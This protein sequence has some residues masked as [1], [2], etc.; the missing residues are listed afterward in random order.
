MEKIDRLVENGARHYGRFANRPTDANPLD[1]FGGAARR[2]RWL[3]L[4]EWLGWTLVH[5]EIYSSMI[6]QDAHYL[7]SS[8]IYVRDKASGALHQHARNAR[9]GSLGIPRALWGSRPEIAAKG[10]G[11][12]YDLAADGSV[13]RITVDIA[14]TGSE[15]A[16]S[17][18]LEVDGSAASPALSVS[19]RLPGGAMYTH[20][21]VFPVSG[22]LRVGDREIVFDPSRDLAILDEHKSFLPY[23][24]TWVWG[25]FASRTPAGEIIGAN[26]ARRP[27]LPGEQEESCL[28]VPGA[29]EPLADID[30]SPTSPD[31]LA[32]WRI[33]SADRRLDVTFTPDGRKDVKH[34][35]GL[36]AIDYFQLYG[37]YTGTMRSLDGTSHEVDV[38]GVCESMRMRS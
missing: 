32:P 5:P 4:K 11:I 25:T 36:L 35:L 2:W 17:G 15:P 38:Q 34:Q 7:A 24:T 18:V 10:Y 14:A 31:D 30:F 26:F 6:L 20:K 8:E 22:A 29:A 13:H 9:G 37:R 12:R 16:L 21:A 3:R 27:E 19:S 28:W 23:R 33:R 1:E